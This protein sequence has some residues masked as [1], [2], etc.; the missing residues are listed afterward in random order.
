MR[1]TFVFRPSTRPFEIPCPTALRIRS[2]RHATRHSLANEDLSIWVASQAKRSS[3][4]LLKC[5][6]GLANGTPSVT[7]PCVGQVAYVAWHA[8][9]S[10]THQDRGVATATRPGG[11]RNGTGSQN[12]NRG[13]GAG[14]TR[15]G[16]RAQVTPP[17]NLPQSTPCNRSAAQPTH[18]HVR[19]APFQR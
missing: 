13:R 5:A 10:A 7:T 1:R 15:P 19:R 18:I 11:C 9:P 12:R 16:S 2:R 17:P 14:D 3:K 4:S 6:P 8:P